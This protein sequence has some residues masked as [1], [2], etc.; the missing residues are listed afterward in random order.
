MTS[1]DGSTR[2]FCVSSSSASEADFGTYKALIR[3]TLDEY[4]TADF[5]THEHVIDFK[6]TPT[7]SSPGWTNSPAITE[8]LDV[9]TSVNEETETRTFADVTYTEQG[10]FNSY[11]GDPVYTLVGGDTAYLTFDASTRTLSV[12]T[13]DDL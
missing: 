7:C 11:C 10:K 5:S 2:T 8:S 4:P 6:V 13:N 1:F 3:I 12:Y 9:V